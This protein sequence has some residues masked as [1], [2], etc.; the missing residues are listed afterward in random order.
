MKMT[1]RL[2]MS[3]LA[4]TLLNGPAA[5]QTIHIADNNANAPA[6][7]NVHATL[8]GAIDA[9]SDGDII[10]VVPSPAIYGSV[11]ISKQLTIYGIGHTPDKDVATTARVSGI[12]LNKTDITSDASGTIISGLSFAGGGIISFAATNSSDI[13]SDVTIEKCNGLY[14]ARG[15]GSGGIA[16]ITIRNNLLAGSGIDLDGMSQ[17]QSMRIYNNVI[18][19]QTAQ[20]SLS[21]SAAST[22]N[23]ISNNIIMYYSTNPDNKPI[24]IYIGTLFI[25]NIITRSITSTREAF[26][27]ATDCIISNNIFYGVS[28]EGGS[29]ERNVFNNNLTFSTG[30]DNLPPTGTGV[31]NTGS[32]NLVGVDP[33]FTDYP[34]EGSNSFSFDFDFNLQSGSPG[35]NAGTDGTD[36]GIFGGGFPFDL[37]PTGSTLPIIQSFNFPSVVTKGTDITV[38]V[39]AKG[40]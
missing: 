4:V 10:H 40:N 3:M 33:Q 21:N 11:T 16:N 9:A 31:G 18:T 30:N 32:N 22:D 15:N 12:V 24:N 36:I 35:K 14:I 17:T 13:I 39:K 34:A 8:Q 23:V 7:A 38:T 6:G 1:I 29:L 20:L 26:A 5:A 27:T 25:N 2:F 19:S 37:S 28:P